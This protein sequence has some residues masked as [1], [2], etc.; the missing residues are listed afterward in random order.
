MLKLDPMVN[1][2]KYVQKDCISVSIWSLRVWLGK[3][4]RVEV[5]RKFV[6]RN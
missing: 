5:W 4:L 6:G 3:V 1:I 2:L